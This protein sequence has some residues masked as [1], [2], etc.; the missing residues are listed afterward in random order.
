MPHPMPR[1][2]I[3]GITGQD[4]SYLAELLLDKGYEVHGLVRRT[5]AWNI[6]PRRAPHRPHPSAAASFFISR[7]DDPTNRAGALLKAAPPDELYHLAGQSHVGLSFEIPEATCHITALA[8]VRLLELIRD[9]IPPP[10]FFH[11]S[12]SEIFGDPAETPQ[13]KRRTRPGQSL[14]CAQ[15]FRDPDGGRLSPRPRAFRVQ[16]HPFQSRIAPTRRAI[17]DPE[18]LPRGSGDQLGVAEGT[19]AGRRGRPARIGGMR[20]IMCS[21]MW[22]ALQQPNP[23]ISFSPRVPY[24]PR[25]GRAGLCRRPAGLDASICAMTRACLARP[26]TSTASVPVDEDTPE[27]A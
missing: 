24:R 10:R 22:L 15:G 18:N 9:L 25:R 5:C 3:T 6:A 8:T 23:T 4:G 26:T 16:R 1:A 13:G 19:A 27:H 21:G 2:L 12:S 7:T 14:R 17:C 11:A 20:P